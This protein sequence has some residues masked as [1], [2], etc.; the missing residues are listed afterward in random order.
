[1]L[2]RVLDGRE[3]RRN[4]LLYLGD[5]CKLKFYEKNGEISDF[6]ITDIKIKIAE[7]FDIFIFDINFFDD[8]KKHNAKGVTIFLDII[9]SLLNLKQNKIEVEKVESIA[10]KV[11][12]QYK[13][14]EM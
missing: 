11:I 5:I 1:M 4:L 3:I 8:H 12:K 14:G 2:G 6:D 13:N 10:N 7:E 9:A